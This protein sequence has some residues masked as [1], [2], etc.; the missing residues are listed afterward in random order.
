MET[1]NV[2][3]HD[4]PV[5]AMGRMDLRN[6]YGTSGR[7]HSWYSCQFA[8]GVDG[9]LYRTAPKSHPAYPEETSLEFEWLLNDDV[10][11]CNDTHIVPDI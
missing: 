8:R 9:T 6:H 2:L 11:F 3:G 1:I 4:I 7:F 5:A 10:E